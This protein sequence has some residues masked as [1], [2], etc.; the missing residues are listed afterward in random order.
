MFIIFHVWFQF[1][2]NFI[3]FTIKQVS[4]LVG[5]IYYYYYKRAALRISDPRF[6]EDLDM[7]RDKP[8]A[9]GLQMTQ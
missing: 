7:E 9:N 1:L 6:Y 5:T 3:N 4:I 8:Q 2:S